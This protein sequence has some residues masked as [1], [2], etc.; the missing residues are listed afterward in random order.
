VRGLR[1][2]SLLLVPG[3]FVAGHELGYA[4]ASLVVAAP[5]T[6]GGHGYL[7]LVVLV[8]VPF[9]LAASAR[10]FLAGLR[11]QL[12]PVGLRTLA[13]AQVGL[14]LAVELAE[15]LAA[16]LGPAEAL[17]Q[18]A[19]VLGLVAQ[20][21]VATLLHLIVLTFAANPLYATYELAPRVGGID[22]L[23][24]QQLAGALMKV[25]SI[26]LIWPVIGALF[27]RWS[28]EGQAPGG[29]RLA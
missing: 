15:H 22:A 19:V 12:P 28:R 25:G 16:G 1:W 14:F 17:A 13:L 20:V 4:G 3:G 21:A 27:V 24:D 5:V 29:N 26:P 9:A 8:G 2:W 6:G 7:A 23:A 10:A 18:P 11:H